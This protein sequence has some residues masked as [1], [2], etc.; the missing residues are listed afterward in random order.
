MKLSGS[1]QIVWQLIIILTLRRVFCTQ[2][3]ALKRATHL[4]VLLLLTRNLRLRAAGRVRLELFNRDYDRAI[5]ACYQTGRDLIGGERI[6]LRSLRH[7]FDLF[8]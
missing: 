1:A 6:R 5:C 8:A 4:F 3:M 7:P 2:I